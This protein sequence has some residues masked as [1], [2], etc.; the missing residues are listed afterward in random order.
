LAE[1]KF[2]ASYNCRN[3]VGTTPQKAGRLTLICSLNPDFK[4]LAAQLLVDF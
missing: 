3:I 4:L 2:R 1:T